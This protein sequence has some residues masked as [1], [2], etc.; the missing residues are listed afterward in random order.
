MQK[1]LSLIDDNRSDKFG[2]RHT[3]AETD[4]PKQTRKD[5]PEVVKPVSGMTE[6]EKSNPKSV[7]NDRNL[8]I[9][10]TRELTKP[11]ITLEE[12][13]LELGDSESSSSSDSSPPSSPPRRI[14]D[15]RPKILSTQSEPPLR[16]FGAVENLSRPEL[17]KGAAPGPEE[18]RQQPRKVDLK[19]DLDLS[20]DSSVAGGP[21]WA[22]YITPTPYNTPTTP[23][24][25]SEP[26]TLRSKWLQ[27]HI[28]LKRDC[29]S[30]R[31]TSKIQDTKTLY[32]YYNRH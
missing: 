18:P 19:L 24:K 23:G 12:I 3:E 8:W 7:K 5:P 26:L 31:S 28:R 17:N 1:K 20:P 16:R 14:D 9:K 27:L 30:Y 10:T 13:Q 6:P 22:R 21:K 32:F 29:H 15:Y 25:I 4:R 11:D 2:S